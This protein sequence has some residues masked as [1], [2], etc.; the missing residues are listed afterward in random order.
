M[1]KDFFPEALARGEPFFLRVSTGPWRDIGTPQSY[2]EANYEAL[3]GTGP[4]RSGFEGIEGRRIQTEED[5]EGPRF[6][7]PSLIGPGAVVAPGAVV[8][9]EAVVGPACLVGPGARVSKSVLCEGSRVGE[10]AVLDRVIV[11]PRARVPAGAR[12]EALSIIV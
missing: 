5:E 1:E 11:G 10:G 9:P 3:R 7:P 8:G 12:P 6:L 4:S 2:L